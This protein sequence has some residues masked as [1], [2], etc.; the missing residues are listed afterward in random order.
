MAIGVAFLS[1][2]RSAVFL[3]G[4]VLGIDFSELDF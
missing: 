2:L 1:A 3:G 4:L